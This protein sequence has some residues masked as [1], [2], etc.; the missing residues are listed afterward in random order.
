MRLNNPKEEK[1]GVIASFSVLIPPS[2][3]LLL[4]FMIFSIWGMSNLDCKGWHLY[5]FEAAS[6]ILNIQKLI[7]ALHVGTGWV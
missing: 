1:I 7:H 4:S 5:L 2:F 3:Y 6:T